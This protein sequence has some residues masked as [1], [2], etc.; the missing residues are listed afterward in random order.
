MQT[1][2]QLDG[3]QPPCQLYVAVQVPSPRGGF[4]AARRRSGMPLAAPAPVYSVPSLSKL[5]SLIQALFTVDTSSAD[6]SVPCLP[7]LFLP[8]PGCCQGV[9]INPVD[10]SALPCEAPRAPLCT[11]T[12]LHRIPTV[13]KR[14]PAPVNNVCKQ[15]YVQPYANG[16][17]GCRQSVLLMMQWRQQGGGGGSRSRSGWRAQCLPE[18]SPRPA[19][20]SLPRTISACLTSS[21]HQRRRREQPQPHLLLT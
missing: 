7:L 8:V 4:A 17:A 16:P 14:E 10:S 21:L 11:A 18:R 9:F 15:Q 6:P 12:A 2:L 1:P 3:G 19:C 20:P 5:F 13:D